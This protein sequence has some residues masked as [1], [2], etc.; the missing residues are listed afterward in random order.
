MV[1]REAFKIGVHR[2][3]TGARVLAAGTRIGPGCTS[4]ANGEYVEASI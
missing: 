1:D 4:N 3:R 2:T